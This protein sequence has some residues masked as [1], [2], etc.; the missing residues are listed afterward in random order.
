M[1]SYELRPTEENIKKSLLNNTSGRNQGIANFIKNLEMIDKNAVIALDDSWGNGKTFFVKQLKLVLQ[2]YNLSTDDANEITQCMKPYLEGYHSFNYLPI[3]YDAWCNDSDNDPVLSMV[4]NMLQEIEELNDIELTDTDWHKTIVAALELVVTTFSGVKVKDLIESINGANPLTIINKHKKSDQILNQLFDAI[5]SKHS[6]NLKILFIIDEL[7]RCRPDYAV[8]TLERIKHYFLH[9]RVIFILST[10]MK[11]LQH[12]IKRYYGSELDATKYLT[13]FYD[14]T[15]TLPPP[16]MNAYYSTLNF[17]SYSGARDYIAKKVIGIYNFSMRD[18]SRY[19]QFLRT[20]DPNR[21]SKYD[22][23][24]GFYMEVIIP[25]LFGLKIHSIDKY[26]DFVQGR[27]FGEFIR[28]FKK[29]NADMYCNILLNEKETFNDNVNITEKVFVSF[30]KRFELFYNCIFGF[31]TVHNGIPTEEKIGKGTFLGTDKKIFLD[32][33]SFE[34]APRN[35][36][37]EK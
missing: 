5:F 33:M 17:L 35:L 28:F 26:E 13:R 24:F 11:E 21:Y 10:N 31:K 3:Y 37:D 25:F 12:T 27:D 30:E 6:E 18:I 22:N 1:I 2:K 19:L 9:D 29:I 23:R 15:I 34:A 4:Y 8:K 14:F 16:D 36:Q 32:I 20:A 7:D